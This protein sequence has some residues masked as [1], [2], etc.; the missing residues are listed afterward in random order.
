MTSS[1]SKNNYGERR[2]LPYSFTEQGVAMLSAVL[3]SDKAIEIS[4]NII[5]AFIEMRKI[6]TM[7]G[8]VFDRIFTLEYKQIENEKKFD[9]IF[10][11]MQNNESIK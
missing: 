9:E 6:L 5:K 11:L 2:Y 8:Q 3:H 10:D 1:L 4:I 7:N